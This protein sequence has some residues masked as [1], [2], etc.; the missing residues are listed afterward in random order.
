MIRLFFALIVVIALGFSADAQTSRNSE[1]Y[2]KVFKKAGAKNKRDH[3][4][5]TAS[6]VDLQ[7][8]TMYQI[9]KQVAFDVQYP[10]I[11][12]SDNGSCIL[13]SGFAGEIEF[14]D[15]A[16][17]SRKIL[18]LFGRSTAEYEQ[19]IKCSVAGD[20]AAVL[21]S[22]PEQD[23]AELLMIDL[24]GNELWRVAMSGKNA[25]EVFLSSDGQTIAVGSYDVERNNFRIT[26][27]FDASGKTLR[28]FNV[29]FRYSDIAGDGRIALA[30]RDNIVL[31]SL[32]G[33]DSPVKWSRSSGDLITSVRF[34]DG[35]VALTVESVNLP[36]GSPVYSDPSLVVLN[37]KGKEVARTQLHTSSVSP[38]A[39]SIER[40]RLT[41]TSSSSKASIQR[42][43]LK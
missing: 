9:V 43:S 8:R 18:Q 22:A 1:Y 6:I 20:R 4:T 19:V 10:A 38:A 29:L 16:G 32:R 21:Y 40:T 11:C 28:T 26:E 31:A 42:S 24:Q 39:L 3:N 12:L 15:N 33:G 35:F 7:G 30:D 14:Y 17:N 25:G 37:K 36:K 23:H 13:V 41:L 27:T 2:S 34:V 5:W